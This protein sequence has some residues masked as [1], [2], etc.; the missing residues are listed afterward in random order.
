MTAVEQAPAVP[1]FF[2]KIGSAP[3]SLRIGATI[4]M[5]HLIIA[6]TGPFWAPYGFSQMG[7]G[8]PLTPASFEHPFGIDQLGRDVFSRVIHGSHLV[9]LLALSGTALGL[10]VGSIVGLLSGYA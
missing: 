2:A 10:V 8:L 9:L 3:L 6:V 7:T 1:G 4:L 5:V